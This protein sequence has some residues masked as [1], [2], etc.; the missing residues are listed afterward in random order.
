MS[1][2]QFLGAQVDSGTAAR[3]SRVA[4]E[5][6]KVGLGRLAIY[7]YMYQP[8]RQ[9]GLV[10]PVL[11]SAKCQNDQCSCGGIQNLPAHPGQNSHPRNPLGSALSNLQNSEIKLSK[12]EH[13]S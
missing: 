1:I 12:L 4:D 10:G 6:A 2:M 3:F 8:Q 9:F 7:I 13:R 11:V 5:E